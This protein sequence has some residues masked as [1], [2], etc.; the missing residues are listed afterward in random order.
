MTVNELTLKGRLEKIQMDWF[1]EEKIIE[2]IVKNSN[3]LNLIESYFERIVN[4]NKEELAKYL[5]DYVLHH[6]AVW[7]QNQ[8]T[9]QH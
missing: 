9:L 7:E 5:E 2:K 4:K 6:N 3:F 1:K 8:D